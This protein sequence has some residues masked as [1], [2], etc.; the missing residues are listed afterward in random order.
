MWASLAAGVVLLFAF[1]VWEHRAPFPM[2][3][4]QMVKLRS[5]A[6]SCGVYPLSYVALTG[7]LFYLT[8]L[9]Q[10]VDRWSDLHTGLSWL[11]LNVPFL[12]MAQFADASVAGFRRR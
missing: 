4:S 10:D 9:Y 7:V 11:C 1:V 6:T 12:L 5:F 2:I 8:L 3:P